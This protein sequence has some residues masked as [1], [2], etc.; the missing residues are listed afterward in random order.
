MENAQKTKPEYRTKG[1]Q[2]L[3]GDPKKAIIKLSI[4]MIIAMSANTIYNLADAIWVSGIGPEALAAVGFYFPFLMFLMA[5]S[6]GLGIGGGAAISQRIGSRDKEGANS[7][8]VHTIVLMIIIALT[9]MIPLLLFTRPL[10]DIMGAQKALDMTVTYS[11]IMFAGTIL[12]FFSQIA[13][14]ILRSEGDANRAMIAMLTGAGLNVLL[15]PVFIYVLKLGVAGAAYATVLSMGFASLLL[16]YWLFIEKKTYITFHFKGFHFKKPI[17]KDIFKVGLPASVAQMSMSAMMFIITILV[18]IINKDDGVAVFTTGWRV[19]MIAI[20]PLLGIAT[21]VTS[22]CGATFGAKEYKKLDTG[23]IYAVKMGFIIEI[24]LALFIFILAPS[25]A[26]VFT[27]SAETSRLTKDITTLL[28]YMTLF[29][30]A[31][32]GGMLSSAMFQGTGKG[33]ISL[34][35]TLIRT[36]FLSAPCAAIFGIVFNLGMNGIYTGMIIASWVSSIVA[37]IWARLYITDLKKNLPVT[38]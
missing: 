38:A 29:F 32:A 10:F 17:L 23:Y 37:F 9:V 2:T 31:V 26:Q 28:H 24:C 25:I 20:L 16:F 36:L 4:P 11:Q 14:S 33:E 34:T 12:I 18:S 35:I 13:N 27:W 5:L 15:D 30:P 19:V 21:A 8:A 22:V 6:T 7:V 3:L 1:V